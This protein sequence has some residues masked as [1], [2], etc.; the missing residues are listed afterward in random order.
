M[1]SPSAVFPAS[2]LSSPSLHSWS[3]ISAPGGHVLLV[4]DSDLVPGTNRYTT[5]VVELTCSGEGFQEGSM[6]KGTLEFWLSK[7]VLQANNMGKVILRGRG[8]NCM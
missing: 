2:V 6:E 7:R 4:L 3:Q 1:C 8:M 5:H